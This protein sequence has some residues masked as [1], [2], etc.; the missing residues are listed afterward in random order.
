MAIKAFAPSSEHATRDYEGS[1]KRYDDITIERIT[2]ILGGRCTNSVVVEIGTF[3]PEDM[4]FS[5][6]NWLW[7]IRRLNSE[8]AQD[9]PEAVIGY[10]SFFNGRAERLLRRDRFQIAPDVSDGLDHKYND[11]DFFC[12][13]G[14][15][16]IQMNLTESVLRI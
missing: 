8:L 9:L 15:L 11:I 6:R 16:C 5:V 2:R 10:G 12:L 7:E 1:H 4:Q 3:L 14:F 13:D